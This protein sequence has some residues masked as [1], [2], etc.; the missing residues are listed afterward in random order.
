MTTH[1]EGKAEG[2]GTHIPPARFGS[3]AHSCWCED[4]SQAGG[5]YWCT[6]ARGAG[7]AG[8][9]TQVQ[10]TDL[11]T[12]VL[13]ASRS[14]VKMGSQ[15][16]KLGSARDNTRH[17]TPAAGGGSQLFSQLSEPRL[18]SCT[19]PILAISPKA[20]ARGGRLRS[21]LVLVVLAPKLPLL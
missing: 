1:P 3:P 18:H 16:S 2:S 14:E 4:D 13:V 5:Q 21:N 11:Q 10:P 12:S 8:G 7:Q 15:V 17:S 19:A 20:L 6:R 9:G